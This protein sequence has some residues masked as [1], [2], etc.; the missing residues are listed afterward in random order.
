MFVAASTECFS[1]LPLQDALAR[2]GDLEY[3]RVEIVLR[4]KSRQLRPSQ[5]H[6]DLENA[7]LNC[8]ETH[9]LTP[10]AYVVDIDAEGDEYYAQFSSCCKLA[11]A[12]KVVSLTVPAAELGTPFNAEIERLRELVR[13]ASLEGVLVSV[14]T[15]VGR[16]TQDPDTAVVLCDNV[17][18]L[19][20]TLDP[21][22]YI[23]GP[24]TNGYE[25]VLK[26]VYHVQLRDTSK[27]QL[28]VRVGQGNVEYGRLVNQLGK[29]HYSRALTVDILDT[30]NPEVD[31][32]AEMRKLRLLLESLL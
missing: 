18:G 6:A 15:E 14:K 31:H 10:V 5:V 19:G 4:E 12:T 22:H 7:I 26:H 20:I 21:S 11:K 27:D 16:I 29:Y 24:F 28:Q 9:R 1:Q 3:S 8:R 13:I 17:K 2:I 23:C 32:F 30:V 25:Q